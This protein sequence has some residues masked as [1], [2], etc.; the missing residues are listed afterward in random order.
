MAAP[1]PVPVP[2]PI[3]LFQLMQKFFEAAGFIVPSNQNGCTFNRKNLFHLISL[4]LMLISALT[5]FFF[6]ANTF[7]EYGLSYTGSNVTAIIM[8]YLIVLMNNIKNI[9]CLID[10][11]GKFIQKSK[12]FDEE[13]GLTKAKH[14]YHFFFFKSIPKMI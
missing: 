3:K 8:L 7:Y 11:Y 4:G 12:C 5:F 1:V 9:D 14:N 10:E 13:K 6:G 2:V